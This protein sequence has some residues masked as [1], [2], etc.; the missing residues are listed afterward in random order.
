M[1][2]AYIPSLLREGAFR[3]VGSWEPGP[4][5]ANATP[6]KRLLGCLRGSR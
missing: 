3:G 4:S 6:M 5:F 2:E 1:G